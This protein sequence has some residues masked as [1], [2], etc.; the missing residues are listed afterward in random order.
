MA[1]GI[2]AKEGETSER[3]LKKERKCV[4]KQAREA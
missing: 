1:L 2:Q 3:R 4:K